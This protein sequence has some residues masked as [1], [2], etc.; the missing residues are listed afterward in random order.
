[1]FGLTRIFG[2]LGFLLASVSLALT[3]TSASS[4]VMHDND[5]VR[6]V[7]TTLQPQQPTPLPEPGRHRL[8]V[9]LDDGRLRRTAPDGSGEV[10]DIKSGDVRW[11]AMTG[12]GTRENLSERLIRFV[13]IELKGKRQPAVVVPVLDPIK[14]DPKHWSLVL[15]NDH[16]RVAR[17]RFGPNEEGVRHTHVRNYLVVYMNKQAKGDRGGVNLHLGEGVT[18]H[19]E[20]NPLN[21]AVERIAVE[22]K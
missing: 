4:M 1:V 6:V 17:V 3:Q 20:N 10:L 16:V 14:V 2:V 11:V 19:L 13:E 18:T 15:E 7:T 5:H 22:L 12:G 21:H 9:Y 8:V